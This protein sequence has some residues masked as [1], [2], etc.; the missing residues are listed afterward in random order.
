ML[1]TIDEFNNKIDRIILYHEQLRGTLP[2]IDRLRRMCTEVAILTVSE[3]IKSVRE[4]E[5]IP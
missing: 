3:I 5:M 4:E 1:I 2:D